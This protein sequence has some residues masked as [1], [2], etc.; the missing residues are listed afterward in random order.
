MIIKKLLG[1]YDKTKAGVPFIAKTSKKPYKKQS[2]TFAEYGDVVFSIPV[3]DDKLYKE[4]DDV[5]GQAGEIRE[6]NGKKYGSW[7]FPLSGKKKLEK[8]VEELR[9]QLA[10]KN[11]PVGGSF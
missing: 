1:T 6:F 9:K 5:R 11:D 4:G 10:V 8:E 7:E 2:V 3:F